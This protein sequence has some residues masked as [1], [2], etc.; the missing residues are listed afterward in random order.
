VIK[1]ELETY[2]KWANG[3]V[4]GFTLYDDKGELEDS[5]YGFYDIDDIK[6]HLPAEWKD[7]D[8]TAYIK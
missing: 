4:Y 7:E 3:E 1:S 5:C 8:L 6:E 2:T